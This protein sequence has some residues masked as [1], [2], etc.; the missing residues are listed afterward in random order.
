MSYYNTTAETGNI[1]DNAWVKTANQ[2]ELVLSIFIKNRTVVFTPHEIQSILRDDYEKLFPITSVRRS[3][4]TLTKR[5]A[6]EK[7]TT[8]RKGGWGRSN[9]CWKYKE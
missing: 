2:D 7:T 3:I 1:L 9:Y 8:K 5:E 6:L 4:N